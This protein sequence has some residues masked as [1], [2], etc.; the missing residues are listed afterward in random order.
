MIMIR[1]VAIAVAA[2]F[3]LGLST[4]AHAQ[5][6][7]RGKAAQPTAR[8]GKGVDNKRDK[9]RKKIRSMRAW[10][11]TEALDLDESTAAKLFPIINE[12][13]EK[14]AKLSRSTRDTRR[15]LRKA[16][17]ASK[18]DTKTVDSLIDEMQQQQQANYEWQ[19]DR[20]K[21]VRKVLTPEQS[22]KIIVIL[23]ELDRQIRQEIRNAMRGT[24]RGKRRDKPD[25]SS[26]E[27][28]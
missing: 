20:F 7:S 8:T 19:R 25:R 26:K 6:R 18:P 13:D 27:R 12:Y 22:A 15:K 2:L 14:Y 11:L 4:A 21:A 24:K 10:R 28:F 23:P 3:I 16:L 17:D 9:I 5:R 1:H